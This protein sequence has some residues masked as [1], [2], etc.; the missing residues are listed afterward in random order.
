[1]KLLA[2]AERR[3]LNVEG[4]YWHIV[5]DLAAFAAT[6]VA[7]LVIVLAGLLALGLGFF[8]LARHDLERFWCGRPWCAFRLARGVE[9]CQVLSLTY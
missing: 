7:G 8:Q 2:S 9:T 5:T 3:S 1:M 6:L 4:A